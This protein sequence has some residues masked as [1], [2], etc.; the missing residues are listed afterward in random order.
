MI[1]NI[2]YQ[3]LP[4]DFY[5]IIR[6]RKLTLSEAFFAVYFRGKSCR[7]GSPFYLNNKSICKELGISEKVLRKYRALLQ[8]K[9][10]IKFDGGKGKGHPTNYIMLDTVMLS[11]RV[12]KQ[13]IKGYQMGT[14]RCPNGN[15]SIYK[16][17]EQN[18]D[19]KDFIDT[20][21]K[22]WKEKTLKTMRI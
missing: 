3:K 13:D 2:R 9:G 1:N 10:V 12:P 4:E 15:L 17:K 22:N 7:F 16:N 11:Q 14:L 6:R 18:N 19:K 21:P 5:E 20:R 8:Q